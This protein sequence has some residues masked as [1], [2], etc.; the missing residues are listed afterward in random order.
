MEKKKKALA[1]PKAQKARPEEKKQE[2]VIVTGNQI[3]VAEQ[4]SEK[5]LKDYLQVMG[6]AAGFTDIEREVFIEI[7]KSQNLNP[8]KR[9]I[10]A[11]ASKKGVYV[12]S[13][14]SYVDTPCIVIVV[15]YEVYLKRAER[16]KL[17]T[18]W[19]VVLEKDNIGQKAILTIHRKDWKIPFVHEVYL[20]EVAKQNKIW[21]T[22]PMFQLKKVA[23]GQGFR[24][25]FP[26]EFDGL[27][28][29]DAEMEQSFEID[30]KKE[31]KKEPGFNYPEDLKTKK[32]DDEPIIPEIVDGPGKAEE[33]TGPKL[34]YAEGDIIESMPE[35]LKLSV[36]ARNMLL[37]DGCVPKKE[38]DTWIVRAKK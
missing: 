30:E 23:I 25:C 19:Y 21:Q 29:I 17:I 24:L 37:P 12:P 11:Y 20:N 6:L 26:V 33:T 31:P 16:T 2:L 34:K 10:H 38:G 14:R 4:V 1:K 9:E 32:T 22:Q 18:G 35:F 13:S 27:P 5:K 3:A 7:A 28:Y 36:E 8:F 15:G